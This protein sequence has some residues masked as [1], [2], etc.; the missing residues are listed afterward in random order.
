MKQKKLKGCPTRKRKDLTDVS[1]STS[2]PPL[3]KGQLRCFL[4]LSVSNIFWT[5]SKPPA[6]FLVRVRWWGE[7]SEGTIFLPRDT[8]QTEQKTRKTTT[9]YPVRCGP[10]Q[11][12]SYLT[13]R[14]SEGSCKSCLSIGFHIPVLQT[15][16]RGSY[17]TTPLTSRLISFWLYETYTSLLARGGVSLVL[18]PLSEMYDSSSSV[19]NTDVSFSVG[20]PAQGAKEA[21]ESVPM[22]VPPPLQKPSGTG[23]TGRE[24]VSSSRASTPR[25][26]DHLYFQENPENVGPNHHQQLRLLTSNSERESDVRL[27][28]GSRNPARVLS[29]NNPATKELLSALLD[30]GSRLRDAMVA[31][32]MKSSPDSGIELGDPPPP[33]NQDPKCDR[34]NLKNLNPGLASDGPLQPSLDCSEFDLQAEDKAIQLLLGGSDLSPGHLLDGVGSPPESLPWK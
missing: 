28:G 12:A 23:I 16:E 14:K 3:V 11:F 19:P 34:K 29:C 24:S 27:T 17:P 33:P 2:L 22:L 13:G 1:P 8:A 26:K 21:A 20:L 10:K 15:K 18:E 32:A 7:T 6:S 30:Q 9:R 5:V 4:K 31:S 25:G